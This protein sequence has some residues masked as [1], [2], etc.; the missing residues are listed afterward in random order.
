M[1]CSFA[2]RYTNALKGK[3]QF[4]LRQGRAFHKNAVGAVSGRNNGLP[5]LPKC[6]VALS[7]RQRRPPTEKLL[8]KAGRTV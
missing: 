3:F 2:W 7:R 4:R 6:E 1:N 8:C 5:T